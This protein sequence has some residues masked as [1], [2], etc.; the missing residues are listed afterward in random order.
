M[1]VSLFRHGA[2]RATKYNKYLKDPNF[3]LGVL[4]GPGM[5]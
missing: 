2:R 3:E 5:R 4:T 1:V